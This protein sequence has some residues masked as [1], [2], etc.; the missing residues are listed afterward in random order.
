MVWSS[1]ARYDSESAQVRI[2]LIVEVGGML[3][4]YFTLKSTLCRTGKA[5]IQPA[6]R[7]ILLSMKRNARDAA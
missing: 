5:G 6:G 2:Q 4:K 3:N 1:R 7:Q